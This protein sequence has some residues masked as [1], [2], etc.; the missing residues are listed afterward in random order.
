MFHVAYLAEDDFEGFQAA[1]TSTFSPVDC[2]V[3]DNQEKH[4]L[5]RRL[6]YFQSI[7]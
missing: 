5:L 7:F 2:P 6:Q 4:D 1:L 3:G